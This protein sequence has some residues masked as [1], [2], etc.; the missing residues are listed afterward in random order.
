MNSPVLFHL[1]SGLVCCNPHFPNNGKIPHNVS[2]GSLEW[3]CKM[4]VDWR[5]LTINWVLGI[6]LSSYL[7]DYLLS[8]PIYAS[9]HV[10]MHPW[11]FMH[12]SIHLSLQSAENIFHST[13]ENSSGLPQILEHFTFWLWDIFRSGFAWCFT[14]QGLN[15]APAESL[16]VSCN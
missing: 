15:S 16:D 14:D 5:N 11:I 6:C 4:S 7:S 12:P 8:T 13:L 3:L 1:S 2:T 9:I 10:S